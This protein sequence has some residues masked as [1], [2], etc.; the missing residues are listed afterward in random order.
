MYIPRENKVNDM[1]E[2]ISFMRRFNFA[3][4]VTNCDDVP[5]ATHLPFVIDE[6]DD[7]IVLISHFA[8][9]NAHWQN[10]EAN[11]NLVIFTEPHAYISP[12]H[13]DK[14]QSVPTWNYMSIHAYGRGRIIR[15]T[16][17]VIKVLETMIRTYESA[18]QAQWDALQMSYKEAMINGIM[19]FEITV[20]D[21]QYNQKL[22][23]DKKENE[24][25]SIINS[26][27]MSDDSTDRILGDYMKSNQNKK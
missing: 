11:S 23:Q 10:I 27:A 24:R 19:A 9:A 14:L 5:T 17:Q 21:L 7:A 4:V 26:L 1:N 18:Y 13:Y 22:S 15:D 20:D 25:Q 8:K 6:R 16:D 12:K 3:T 2:A